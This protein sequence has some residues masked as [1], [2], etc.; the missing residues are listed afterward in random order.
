L[1]D[2]INIWQQNVN[3][4]P[5]CQHNL[6]SSDKLTSMNIDIVAIQEP[7]MINKNHSIASKEWILVYPMM[8]ATNPE[9]TRSLTL[10]QVQISMDS[11][12]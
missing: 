4:L 9:K 11:W 2:H 10:I 3:K 6:L 8:H 1:K 5:T 7:A 12:N